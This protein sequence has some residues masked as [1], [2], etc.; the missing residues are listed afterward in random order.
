MESQKD[1]EAKKLLNL[2]LQPHVWWA[3]PHRGVVQDQC[4]CELL[5]FTFREARAEFANGLE[6]D[7]YRGLRAHVAVCGANCKKHVAFYSLSTAP[8]PNLITELWADGVDSS[9]KSNVEL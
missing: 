7:D 3:N 2:Y 1:Q 5:C 6:L 4:G 8:P 9:V